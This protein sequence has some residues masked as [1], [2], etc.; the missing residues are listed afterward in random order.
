MFALIYGAYYNT[1]QKFD[2]TN[3]NSYNELVGYGSNDIINE[4]YNLYPEKKEEYNRKQRIFEE[5]E[6][7][8]YM[9]QLEIEQ[10]ELQRLEEENYKDKR[11]SNVTD[12]M[13][14]YF[15]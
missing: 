10:K 2:N 3:I 13:K 1:N 6:R 9:E 4:Y 11:I 14:L 7:R 5:D 8:K 15:K 12:I